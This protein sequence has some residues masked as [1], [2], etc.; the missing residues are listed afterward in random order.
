MCHEILPFLEIRYLISPL[1]QHGQRRR[2]HS[3]HTQAVI[4]SLSKGS[5]RIHADQPV[6]LRPAY[7]RIR[8]AFVFASA[9]QIGKAIFDRII[10][11]RGNP[12]TLHRDMAPG[13]VIYT[14]EDQLPF[15]SCI[16]GIDH[17]FEVITVQK[18]F[19]YSK[20]AFLILCNFQLPLIWNDWK[21]VKAPLLELFIIGF[22]HGVLRQ[23]SQAPADDTISSGQIPVLFLIRTQHFSD[24]LRYAGLFTDNQIHR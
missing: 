16:A 20:L 8:K 10:L 5:G 7:G 4:I 6:S 21:I 2:L 18:F 12:K 14:L 23:M 1:Y 24:G 3:S 9:F 15:P 19:Q 17:I 22:G 13:Q 11:H